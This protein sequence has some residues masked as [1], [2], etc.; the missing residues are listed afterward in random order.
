MLY[1]HRIDRQPLIHW[2]HEAK[3]PSPLSLQG[4]KRLKFCVVQDVVMLRRSGL[5][6]TAWEGNEEE[7]SN[8]ADLS[9]LGIVGEQV[10]YSMDFLTL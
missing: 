5:W 6:S 4:E 1:A 3:V 8:S 9:D 7:L 2:K 10:P